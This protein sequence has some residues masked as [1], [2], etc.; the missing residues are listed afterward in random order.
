M[1][2]GGGGQRP[3]GSFT[4]IHPKW[5]RETSLTKNNIYGH[6]LLLRRRGVGDMSVI[7]EE[8]RSG[9]GNMSVIEEAGRRRI[10]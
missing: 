5:N 6:C 10:G 3:F 4:Q 2:A 7:E 8:R 1:R 9:V